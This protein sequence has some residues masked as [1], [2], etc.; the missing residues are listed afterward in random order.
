MNKTLKTLAA[1]AALVT[2]TA[3]N[4]ALIPSSGTV[5]VDNTEFDGGVGS[6]NI[7]GGEFEANIAGFGTFYTFCLEFDQQI[8][9][10]GTYDYNLSSTVDSHPDAISKGTAYLYEQFIK[11]NL[12]ER[13]L[14]VAHDEAAGFLQAAIW[15]LEDED[16][17][18]LSGLAISK[19]FDVAT[20]PF[21]GKAVSAFGSL[22]DAK[23]DDNL[24]KVKVLNLSANG[25]QF[26][27]VLVYVP[28][29]GTT[30][31]LLGLALGG[32]AVARRRR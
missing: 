25:E 3:T 23:V 14:D 8:E 5:E 19:F 11:G 15:I 9:L 4:A 1:L 24:G 18:S 30:L 31:A 22:V 2:A 26:Q 20:N 16:Y 29:S 27:D 21:I 7:G 28:D 12:Y 17:S 6:Y 10:P 32:I 13:T